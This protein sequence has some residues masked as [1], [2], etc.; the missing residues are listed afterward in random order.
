MRKI[1]FLDI[2]GV[3]NTER[4]HCQ[5]DSNELQDEYGY[6]F[7]PVAVTNLSKIIEETGADIVISSSWKFMGLS[8]MRK[9]WKDRKLPGNVIGITPNT[10]SDEFLLNVDLDNMDIMAIRGQEV[11]EWLMLNKNEITNYVILDDMNDIIQE[12]E[13]HFVWIDPEV[14]ITSGNAVQAIFILNHTMHG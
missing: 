14:G 11:K 10:V 2:D 5:T 6:K 7:D 4:W 9:M 3:L 13:S 12:Q 8:K 1:I